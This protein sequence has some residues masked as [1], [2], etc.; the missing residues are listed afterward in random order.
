MRLFVDLDTQQINIDKGIN[1][2]LSELRVKRSPFAS[3]EVQ[4]TRR[5]I[6]QELPAGATGSFEVKI[7][8]EFDTD[9]LTAA[10]AMVQNG[11]GE[12]TVY[13]F[14]LV[15]INEFLN[16]QLHIEDPEAFTTNFGA[17]TSLLTA[18]VASP[19]VG[20][21]IQ[22]TTD[23]A[24]SNGLLPN[25]DYWV[26]ATGWTS[27]TFKISLTV[28]GP[29]V[30]FS[31]N[32]TGNQF[33]RRVD[34]DLPSVTLMAAVQWIADGKELESQNIDFVLLNDICRTG[35]LP[36]ST[37]PLIYGIFLDGITTMADFKAVPTVSLIQG[38]LVEILISV[39]GTLTWLTYRLES[40]PAVASEPEDVAPDD[41]NVSTNDVHWHGAAGPPG[42]RGRSVGARYDWNTSTAATDPTSGRIKVDVA[43]PYTSVAKLRISETDQDGNNLEDFL[44]TL[45]DSSST[46]KGKFYIW[47]PETPTNF[48]ILNATARTDS[49][50]WDTFDVTL[51]DTGGSLTNGLDV[52]VWFV[53]TG[54]KG[55]TGREGG[56]KYQYNSS[57]V[58]PPGTGKFQFDVVTASFLSGPATSL[59]ISETDGDGNNLASLLATLVESNGS[60]KAQVLIQKADGTGYF[61]FYVTGNYS[62]AGVYDTFDIE[63]I[64][65][66]GTISNNDSVYIRWGLIGADGSQAGLS[67]I[68][69]ATVGGTPADGGFTF[70]NATFGSITSMKIDGDENGTSA[71]FG[72]FFQTLDDGLGVRRCLIVGLN[73]NDSSIPFAFYVTGP[74]TGTGP[75][76][77]YTFPVTP[78]S[79]GVV[80]GASDPCRLIF[81][82]LDAGQIGF[83]YLWR[84][85]TAGTASAGQILLNTTPLELHFNTVTNLAQTIGAYVDTWD[86]SSST[87]HGTV[88]VIS[89]T[90]P[91]NFKIFNVTGSVGTTGS[92]K[93]VGVAA[94]TTGGS[95]SDLD[96]VQVYFVRTGDIGS[97]GPTGPASAITQ[98]YDSTTSAADPG[99]G[100][101]R[102]NSATISA[103]T[104]GYFDNNESGGTDISAWLD[105]FD[106][107]T[108]T[109]NG[110]LVLKGITTPAKFAIFQVGT[111]T[112]STGYRTLTLTHVASNGTW[113]TTD[114]FALNFY[115]NGDKGDTGTSGATTYPASVAIPA[116]TTPTVDWSLFTTSTQRSL[117]ANTTLNHTNMVDG[118]VILIALKQ[119]TSP[120]TVTWTS[121]ATI[122]WLGTGGSAP[123]QSTG[124]GVVDGYAFWYDGTYIYG[125]WAPGA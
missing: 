109:V 90:N 30:T 95:F 62:D 5:G 78:I 35:D 84:T 92:T 2:P 46:I 22:L 104:S 110:F 20:A 116:G 113:T 89:P 53:P 68:F 112:D 72:N 115:S 66:G 55:D 73:Q 6:V 61:S 31:D 33:F 43:G 83:N 44:A 94:V 71:Q 50:A 52:V 28:G 45:D 87:I 118:K 41:Y 82:P 48:L 98:V 99:S 107:S 24:L 124:S 36:P 10:L 75:G 40:G 54:D 111:V 80:P 70:N 7:K 42:G 117:A 114:V 38:Y 8:G 51:A 11:T 86:D 93:T 34:N 49:G 17:S 81:I 57:T 101:F 14:T 100:K 79:G 67:Y 27:T 96:P 65:F 37:P 32:G 56:L 85:A 105:T 16:D 69:D 15:L 108:S 125:M 13:T 3:I 76:G 123:T 97:T 103:V 21:K 77:T 58:A 122:I 25:T 102:L 60:R 59:R 64:A 63:P 119:D 4:F 26:I 106:D 23:G 121:G 12:N 74:I 29:A 47:D 19:A 9:P 91:A 88:I 39:S 120:R 18:D 1:S